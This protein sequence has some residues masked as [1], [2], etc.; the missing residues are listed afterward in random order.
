MTPRPDNRFSGRMVMLPMGRIQG[1][2]THEEGREPAFSAMQ[3]GR[4]EGR[5]CWMEAMRNLRSQG[6]H[7]HSPRIDIEQ[8]DE[9]GDLFVLALRLRGTGVGSGVDVDAK[10]ANSVRIREGLQVEVFSRRT[11]EEARAALQERQPTA[12]S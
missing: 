2:P 5:R 7:R 11:V 3:H 6:A 10:F 4:T 8:M 1:A 9:E 12:G